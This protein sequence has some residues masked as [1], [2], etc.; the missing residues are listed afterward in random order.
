MA[1]KTRTIICRSEEFENRVYRLCD[2]YGIKNKNIA[3]NVINNEIYVDI[4]SSSKKFD[5]ICFKLGGL[6][7]YYM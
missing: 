7:K 2:R 4:Y 5:Q 3:S 1:K 6:G